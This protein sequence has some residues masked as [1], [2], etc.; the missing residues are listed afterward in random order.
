MAVT[1]QM[2]KE[3]RDKTGAGMAECKKALDEA[4][5]NMDEAIDNLRKRGAASVAK[6][7]DRSANEGAVVALT[8]A[9][10]TLGIM[11]EVNCETDFVARNE[12]FVA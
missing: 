2:V 3:L 12:E 1:P 9:D 8:S 11:A 4:Q 7:A 5:G 10:G 6:R